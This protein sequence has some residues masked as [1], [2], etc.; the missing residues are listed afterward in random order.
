MW[1]LLTGPGAAYRPGLAATALLALSVVVSA[2]SV[3]VVGPADD[4]QA[5][6]NRTSAGDVIELAPGATYSGNFVLP[7][8]ADTGIVTIRTRGEAGQP[9]AGGR[10]APRDARLLAK[11]QS[12][13][14]Q[15]VLRTAPG[16]HGWRLELLEF[17]PNA[18]GVGDIITLGDGSTSQSELRQVPRD[19]TIDRCYI[20]GDPTRGQK[21]GIA[22]NSARTAITGSY[23]ADI[24]GV[25]VDTQAIAGWNGPGPFTIENNY[26]EAAGEAFLL[27]GAT[28]GIRELV[29]SDVTF[30]RNHVSRPSEWRS[31]KWQ[32]K[33]LLELKNARRVTISQN[34]FERN[35][36]AAQQGYAILF[37]PR[38]ERGEAAWATVEDVLFDRNVVRDVA[39]AISISGHDDGGPSGLA[40]RIRISRN[41]FHAFD[42]EQWGGN[43]FFLLIGDGPSDVIVDR[44]TILQRG[45]LIEAYGAVRGAAVTIE[46]FT[47]QNNL[48]LHN[49]FGI[50]GQSRGVGNDTINAY[51]PGGVITH[52]VLAGARASSYPAGN[53]FP[54]EAELMAQF[55][56]ANQG[57]YRLKPDSRY[58]TSAD[59]GT[60]LG[61]PIQQLKRLL[62]II[63]DLRDRPEVGVGAVRR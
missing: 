12:G 32:V 55:M 8:R 10:V 14:S 20:H 51:F 19:L 5:A 62:G 1:N 21:R 56:D 3:I 58:E 6:L 31:E 7:V 16:A 18:Q 23:I 30:T 63:V 46:R 52:N 2:R 42:R 41:L 44:N 48:A 15:P 9:P 59:D 11:L 33:N 36:V 22:L 29:P 43:G 57:D 26:L 39:A 25:G 49:S 60:R 50:H 53:F 4:L 27:G 28:P 45:N 54:T 40:K 38:G 34:L 47:F 13:S 37:T 17:G 24:K 35:W 61:A